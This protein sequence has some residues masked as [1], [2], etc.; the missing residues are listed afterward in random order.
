MKGGVVKS[1][2]PYTRPSFQT[3]RSVSDQW[4]IR[5]VNLGHLALL[6]FVGWAGAGFADRLAGVRDLMGD[7]AL[8]Q[9]GFG[10]VAAGTTDGLP[11]VCAMCDR[12]EP[13]P[14]WF[15]GLSAMEPELTLPLCPDCAQTVA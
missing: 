1:L 14:L 7:L 12:K 2:K 10:A 5:R 9:W 11:V 8:N 3:Y 6:S 13:V 15:K 4:A